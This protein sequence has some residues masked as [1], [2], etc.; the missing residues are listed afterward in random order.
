MSHFDLVGYLR[1]KM[2]EPDGARPLYRQLSHYIRH[3]ITEDLL[4]GGAFMPSE[5]VLSTELDLSRVTV[6]KAVEELSAG[7][8]L[9]RRHGS[10]TEVASRVEKTLSTLTSFS[11]DIRS[12]GMEPSAQW[13]S[14]AVT[15]PTPSEVMALGI[16]PSEKL[17]R[18]ERLRLADAVPIAIERA[19]VPQSILPSADLVEDSLYDALEKLDALPKRALQRMRAGI[20]TPR[21]AQL[22]NCPEGTPMFIVERQLFL[23]DGRTVEFTET[24]YHGDSYDFVIEQGM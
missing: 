2:A 23:D 4:V 19:A 17:V 21:D 5:R 11:E 10:K 9:I 20:V 24:R 18:L 7:G 1:E 3:A 14:R 22:L 8:F 16:S 6:R 13:L 12:R 15:L